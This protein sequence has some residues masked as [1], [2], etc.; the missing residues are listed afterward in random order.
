M[1]LNILENTCV[2]VSFSKKACNFIEKEIAAQAVSSEFCESFK[3]TFFI[4]QLPVT[5][6]ENLLT[7]FG[8]SAPLYLIAFQFSAAF[9]AE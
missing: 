4:E 1:F 9:A 2:G 3:N 8:D 6:S 5:A 7:H